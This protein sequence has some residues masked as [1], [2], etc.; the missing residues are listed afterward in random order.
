M[1]RNGV[2]GF[3]KAFLVLT[4]CDYTSP[5]PRRCQGAGVSPWWR[6]V[7][8]NLAALLVSIMVTP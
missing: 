8:S 2:R 5:H 3:P 6:P 7:G 4:L 1:T